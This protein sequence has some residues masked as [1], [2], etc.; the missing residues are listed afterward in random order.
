ME[1]LNT[2]VHSVC[3]KYKANVIREFERWPIDTDRKV[4]NSSR[5]GKAIAYTY[6][7]LPRL[8]LYVTDGRYNIDDN[9]IERTVRPLAVGRKNWLFCGN[10]AAAYRAAIVYSL[11]NCCRTS[12][13]DSRIWLE[14]VLK[15]LPEYQKKEKDIT[16]LLP[17]HWKVQQVTNEGD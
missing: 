4:L 3:S 7:L 13:V 9:P 1:L 8:S 12:D 6:S 15:R 14:H 11:I 16:K 10:K 2:S 17:H 5:M